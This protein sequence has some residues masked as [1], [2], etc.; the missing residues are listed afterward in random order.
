MIPTAIG[1]ALPLVAPIG[2]MMTD[3]TACTCPKEAVVS[4]E[5]PGDSADYRSF[6]ATGRLRRA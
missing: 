5:V 6:Y 3:G 4:N 1:P 2:L